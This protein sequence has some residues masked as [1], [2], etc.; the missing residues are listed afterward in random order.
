[1]TGMRIFVLV[2][3][4]LAAGGCRLSDA[5]PA[6]DAAPVPDPI[7][8]PPRGVAT[9]LEIASWNVEWFGAPKNG[10]ADEALQSARVRDVIRGT[11]AD[12]WGM[13]EIVDEGAWH[14]LIAELPGYSGFLANDARV[15][16]GSRSYGARE[17]KV[18]ILYKA[19]VATVT[20]ARVIL[21]HADTY[22]AGRPPLEVRMRVTSGRVTEDIVI[23]ILHMKAFADEASRLRRQS[24]ARELK[25]YLDQ[26]R[27]NDLVAVVGDWNDDVDVSIVPGQPTP[28][29]AFVADPRQYRFVTGGLSARR[30]SSTT[31]YRDLVDHHLA[32]N[33]LGALEV[34]GS[35]EVYRVDAFIPEYGRTTSDHFPVI[36]HYRL[37]VASRS[38]R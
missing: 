30:I 36:S 2:T 26:V 3:S 12:I 17:Q 38:R 34:T 14:A 25:T 33:E 27:P 4:L 31:G 15:T 13:A 9:G 11:D 32:T 37:G 20:G 10:P 19:D 22:F 18:G 23:V 6:A 8:V 5:A 16:G 24:A 1:M 35:A 28:F 29:A 7:V 21:A